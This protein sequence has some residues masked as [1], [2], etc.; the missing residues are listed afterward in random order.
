M[1]W[2]RCATAP[3]SATR[4]STPTRSC[5]RSTRG[6]TATRPT[7]TAS[8]A[9]STRS[10]PH[11]PEPSAHGVAGA[12]IVSCGVVIE[13][14]EHDPVQLEQPLGGVGLA[15]GVHLGAAAEPLARVVLATGCQQ[16]VGVGVPEA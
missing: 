8:C 13:V 2:R 9:G 15:G 4:P 14:V 7:S 1:P 5:G 10:N 11:P 3:A 12:V 16:H 6:S